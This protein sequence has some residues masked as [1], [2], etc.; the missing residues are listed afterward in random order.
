IVARG[1][2]LYAEQCIRCP[3]KK[4]EFKRVL[5]ISDRHW[6]FAP[7]HDGTGHTS[8]HPDFALIQLTKSGE[9][10]VTCLPL[11]ENAMPKFEEALTD[12]QVLDVLS[13]IKSTWPE[14][15]VAQQAK[16]NLLY[17]SHNEA[18]WSLLDLTR[19]D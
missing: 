19:P 10:G 6:G 2:V 3:V 8:E 5:F 9:A 18:M 14:E 4:L 12:R 16:V 1:N 13:Y 17:Q 11:D 7:P 15:V